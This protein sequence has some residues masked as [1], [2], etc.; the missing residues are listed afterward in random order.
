MIF[1]TGGTG[2]LGN[3]LLRNLVARGQAVTALYRTEIPDEPFAKSVNWVKGDILDIVLLEEIMQQAKQVYHCAA[4]VS[5]NPAKKYEMLKINAEGTANVVNAALAGGIQKL[6]HVS[7]VSALGR[8]I[9]GNPISETDP[10]DDGKNKSA[11]G[12]SKYFAEL[13]VWR[14]MSEGLNA[15]IINPSTILGVGK[16]EKDGS[17]AIFKKAYEEFPWYTEGVGGFVDVA[18]V[19]KAMIALMDS[20]ITGEKFI[21]SA[22]N[23]PYKDV[24]TSIAKTFGK[25]PPHK[26]A[27][28]FMVSLLWRLEKVRSFFTSKAPLITKET[29]NSAQRKTAYNNSK[30]L[31]F[32]PGF[33]YKPVNET[34]E[35]YCNVYMHLPR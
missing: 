30:L 18:D 31:R 19:A 25:K 3:Y 21:V 27:P 5:F 24:F 28:A 15:V 14:G 22:E 33:C 29:A 17:A 12:K 23:L 13:E 26:K 10:W 32:L 2:L 20:D 34:I 35:E 6:V 7:S 1:V 16:W 4:I 9:Q 8:N 11:Y